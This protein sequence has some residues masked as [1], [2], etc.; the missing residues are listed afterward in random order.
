MQTNGV[1]TVSNSKRLIAEILLV[2]RGKRNTQVVK[3]ESCNPGPRP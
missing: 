1:T 2:Q 3:E